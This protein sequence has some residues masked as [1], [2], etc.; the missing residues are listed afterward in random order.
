MGLIDYLPR[1]PVNPALPASNYDE[2]FVMAK[3]AAFYSKLDKLDKVVLNELANRKRASLKL[4]D[5][6]N[7]QR[8]R[9][10]NSKFR[11][12]TKMQDYSLPPNHTS[13]L[14]KDLVKTPQVEITMDTPSKISTD[15]TSQAEK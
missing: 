10:N 13:R 7:K 4:I 11:K 12:T 2:E 15:P 14:Y 9:Q 6:R 3:S 8:K 1:N 5:I